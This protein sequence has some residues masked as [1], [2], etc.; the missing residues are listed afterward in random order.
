MSHRR[1]REF[2]IPMLIGLVGQGLLSAALT[3]RWITNSFNVAFGGLD[4]ETAAFTTLALVVML[5]LVAVVLAMLVVDIVS[6]RKLIIAG[7][8]LKAASK[9]FV[10]HLLYGAA[11][12]LFLI[13]TTFTTVNPPGVGVDP[14]SLFF[15]ATIGIPH[16]FVGTLGIVRS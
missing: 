13:N 1:W 2:K 11:V 10:L 12:I 4:S 8:S 14:I 7:T 9:V 16:M 5:P 3:I 15:V 6:Y